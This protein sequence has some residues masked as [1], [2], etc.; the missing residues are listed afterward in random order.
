M[1]GPSELEH[2]VLALV[3]RDG[4]S[5]PYAIRRHFLES[6][7]PRWS[8]SAGAIYPLV[9]R[10]EER[11][12][13]RS[14][15]ERT[16]GRGTRRYALTARGRR[17]I[18]RWLGPPFEPGELALGADPVRA[19]LLFLAGLSPE[20]RGA[21]LE[22]VGAELEGDVERARREVDGAKADEAMRLA[23]RGWL[24]LARARAR[25][26]REVRE[27]LERSAS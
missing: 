25:W 2:I 22:T 24:A 11:G 10:L 12:L 19:R 17:A 13:L 18:Q 14:T 16:D 27:A 9:R 26:W 5:T 23:A 7:T 21:F 8:G 6:P 15:P 3:W 20:A 1:S 4:P